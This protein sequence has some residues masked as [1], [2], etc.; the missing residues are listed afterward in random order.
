MSP[1]VARD[2][3][4]LSARS[5]GWHTPCKTFGGGGL[6]VS[7]GLVCRPRL[8]GSRLE[9]ALVG[10][11]RHRLHATGPLHRSR[12]GDGAGLF[13]L[14]DDR[15]W[16]LRARRL[17]RHAG[18]VSAQRLHGA[19][20]RSDAAGPLADAGVEPSRHR[21]HHDHR[22]LSALSRGTP[23]G[24]PRPPHPGPRRPQ[25]RD[26]AQRPYGAEFR[27]RASPR[28]RPALR[29][30][31]RVDPGRRSAV[32]VLGAGRRRRRSGERHVCRF[33]QGPSHRLRREIFQLARTAQ[34]AARPAAPAGDLPGRHVAGGPRVRLEIRR[35]YRRRVSRRRCGEGLS[36]R[37][38]A[39]HGAAR[40][41]SRPLQGD[42]LGRHRAGRDARRGLGQKGAGRRRAQSQHGV[43]PRP[44][45]L[46][47]RQ[48]ISPG[49]RSTSR[50]PRSRPMPR[51]ARPR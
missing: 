19:Q 46:P 29:D 3:P 44:A 30:R 22:L 41:Q 15:G 48:S 25:S 1:Y 8:F 51:A 37:R 35:Y 39:A 45:V 50:C 38:A 13:R 16:L 24:D 33:P 26:G 32:A 20:A 34:H 9:P 40:P 6:D 36:R 11:H 14:R 5:T 31:R 12:P 4:G 28:A 49:S 43:P 2:N 47:E 21:R 17:R 23:G 18:M 27:P 42:V 7:Y 10:H